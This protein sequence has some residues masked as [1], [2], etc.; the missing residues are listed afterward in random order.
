MAFEFIDIRRSYHGSVDTSTLAI[1]DRYPGALR[2]LGGLPHA[3]EIRPATAADRDRLVDWLRG[4]QYADREPVPER[5]D[6]CPI[7]GSGETEGDSID[8]GARGASQECR[9][10]TCGADWV[11][12][13]E[14]GSVTEVT[15]G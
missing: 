5:T 14:I 4:L 8:V 13:F 10:L 11:L 9:C 1:S 2:V 15:E 6:I 3:S 7:C 12:H